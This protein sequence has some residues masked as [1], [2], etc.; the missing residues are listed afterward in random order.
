MLSR[1][2]VMECDS[3]MTCFPTQPFPGI[4]GSIDDLE[5]P[6]SLDLARQQT[7]IAS[8]LM[9]SPFLL[10]LSVSPVVK[11][12]CSPLTFLWSS[13]CVSAI[14]LASSATVGSR[15]NTGPNN[16]RYTSVAQVQFRPL[17]MLL[18]Q[19]GPATNGP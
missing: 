14:C 18:I 16:T 7:L 3:E 1:I 12:T 13:N 9:Q 4:R 6:F 17:T 10:C 5:L 2:D 11:S 19:T 15:A 8:W